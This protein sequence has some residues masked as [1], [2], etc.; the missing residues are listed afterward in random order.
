MALSAAFSMTM[1]M[2]GVASPGG[3]VASLNRFARCSGWARREKEPFADNTSDVR[4]R[5]A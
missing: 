1:I 5:P 3:R 2:T 4:V